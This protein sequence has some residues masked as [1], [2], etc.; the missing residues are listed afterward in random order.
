M[1]LRKPTVIATTVVLSVAFLTACSSTKK[2]VSDVQPGGGTTATPTV[3][4]APSLT[5]TPLASPFE[6]DPAVIALRKW[7]VRLAKNINAGKIDDPVLDALMTPT[8]A[9]LINKAFSGSI[10]H[11]YPGPLPFAP[12]QITKKTSTQ[13]NLN[14]CVVSNGFG[15]DPATGRPAGVRKVL[16]IDTGADLIDGHWIVSGF[17]DGKFS[18]DG[19]QIPEEPW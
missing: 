1:R 15:L 3:T 12:I 9:R 2:Q 14:I 11:S 8:V 19:V 17:Y 16:P 13:H 18:C 10:G 7:A 5:A 4:V 6:D